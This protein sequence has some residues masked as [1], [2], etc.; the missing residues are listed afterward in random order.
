MMGRPLPSASAREA[1]VWGRSSNRIQVE[2]GIPAESLQNIGRNTA[3][4][5]LS[6]VMDRIARQMNVAC[7]G[8]DVAVSEQLSD[9]R[10]KSPR[11]P[12]HGKR[13]C[14]SG[15]ELRYSAVRDSRTASS[16]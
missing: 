5:P 12:A 1:K 3:C 10:Q 15:R 11:A 13:S 6:S 4:D 2:A 14:G 9:H 7:R 16:R 8:L